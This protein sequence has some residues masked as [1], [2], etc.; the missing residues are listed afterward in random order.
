[1]LTLP[2]IVERAAQPYAAI[3][4]EVGLGDLGV[5]GPRLHR[6]LRGWLHAQGIE[7]AGPPFFK[8]DVIDMARAFE[9]EFG[10]PTARTI[11]ATPPV[12]SAILPAGRYATLVH[13]GPYEK[14]GDANA[15]LIDWG[16]ANGISWD[17]TATP[18]GDR[19]AC[20][21]EVYRTDEAKQP[22]PEQWETEVT[23]R[24]SDTR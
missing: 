12:V 8:Y 18:K 9:M 16:K 15:A 13:R 2:K 17:A 3:R 24:V 4:A 22:D 20:R 7:P 14:L 10:F 23:I 6:E 5:S 1:M 19:F 11:G 21:L